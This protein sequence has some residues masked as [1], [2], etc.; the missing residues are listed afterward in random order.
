MTAIDYDPMVV[1]DY[2]PN[3]AVLFADEK[4]RICNAIGDYILSVE[5]VGS[6]SI[7]GLAAKPI[8]DIQVVVKDFSELDQCIPE[9]RNI[10]YTYKGE[11]GIEGRQ[12]FK[13]PLYH[14]HMVQLGNDEYQR[15]KLFLQY[16]RENKSALDEYAS[17]K[18]R[19][20]GKWAGQDDC[21]HRYN[22]DKT[23]FIMG[24]LKKAGWDTDKK[25]LYLTEGYKPAQ[26][27]TE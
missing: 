5:H 20:A 8:I 4:S 27:L 9:L 26:D 25:P 1:V 11:L 23:E 2:D 21:Q 3:W 15:K 6:T 10:G 24:I 16:L 7:P 14:L 12:Y 17:L 22:L 18:K 19:L 13:R